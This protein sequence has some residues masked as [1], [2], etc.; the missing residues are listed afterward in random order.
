M[1]INRVITFPKFLNMNNTWLRRTINSIVLYPFLLLLFCVQVNAQKANVAKKPN[2]VFILIDD[3]GWK[4][5]GT[6]GSSFYE[7]PNIDKL[8]KE[9]MKFTNAYAACPVCSPTRASIL[10]GKYP[11]GLK[12]TD[13]FGAPEP[14]E[15]SKDKNWSKKKLLPAAYTPYLPLEE[16]TIAEALKANGYTTFIAG[17]W[18]LGEEEKYWPEHQGFDVNM[19]GYSKGHP[20]SYF[21]PYNNP[22][23]SD[24]PPGEYLGDR[25]AAE[26]V[27]FIEANKSKPFFAYIS[28]YEVHTPLQSKDSL[29][30]KYE[31]KRKMLG[32]KDEF[33]SEGNGRTRSVQSLPVYAAMVEAMDAAA[34]TVL[35]RLKELNLDKSTIVIFFSDNGGLSTA[36]G[37]PTS[38]LP[39][40]GGKGWLYEGGIREPLV[41]KYPPKVQ[42]GTSCDVPVIS[43]D[44]Y[45]TLLQMVGLPLMPKQHTGGISIAPLLQNKTIERDAL[46]W[47]Y[48]HYGNQGSSPGSAIR[49]GE[50]KLIEWYEDNRI[51]LFNL[52]SDLGERND[53]AEQNP[54]VKTRLLTMLHVWLKKE[55][56]SM[57]TINTNIAVPLVPAQPLVDTNYLADIR[58]ELT[59]KWPGNRFY[60]FVFH[61]HSVVAGYFK[62][63][64]VNTFQSYPMVMLQKLT[65]KYP[66]AAINVIRTA[67]GGENSEQGAVRFDSTVL[68]HMADVLFIDYALNDRKMGV[69]RARIAWVSM[70]EKALARNIK[71]VLFT[72]TPDLNEDITDDKA[73]LVAH[74][75]MILELGKKYCIPVIDSYDIFKKM[76]LAGVDLNEYM[77]QKNHINGRGHL[78]VANEICRLFGIEPEALR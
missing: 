7:T 14:D 48:P 75:V 20:N 6:N 49:M 4:D 31:Q 67:I 43:N 24:G 62:T 10:T 38:N 21:S 41:I 71:V 59:K 26:A 33:I 13:W 58:L 77:V 50:W 74:R 23:L 65:E 45:P 2:I 51:E 55:N 34:G 11:A 56:A 22:R 29:I 1:S 63:P 64:M 69:E 27:K 30:K 42:A 60:N 16:T 66:Y 57:P 18:H 47:H 37:S 54:E 52:Q 70:I 44:F 68:V 19:G 12:T 72:P 35:K 17:K 78:I 53:I 25:V 76:A 61:G 36:E 5:L 32:L 39:L 46:Y 3:M 28:F 15:A 73:P 9:G 8:A 40:R